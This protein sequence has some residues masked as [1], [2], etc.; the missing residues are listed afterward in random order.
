MNIKSSASSYE[1]VTKI[2]VSLSSSCWTSLLRWPTHKVVLHTVSVKKK[3][4]KLSFCLKFGEKKITFEI[5]YFE[6]YR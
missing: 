2:T 6:T 1:R 4:S 3:E 5:D